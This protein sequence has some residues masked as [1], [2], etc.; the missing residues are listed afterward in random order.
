MISLTNHDFQRGRSEVVIVFQSRSTPIISGFLQWHG[1]SVPRYAGEV[2]R[3]AGV[4]CAA[5][6][7]ERG[8]SQAWRAGRFGKGA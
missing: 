7:S 5:R 3:S 8:P 4:F 2:H 6:Q 1:A